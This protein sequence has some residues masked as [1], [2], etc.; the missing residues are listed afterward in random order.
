MLHCWASGSN[1]S[2]DRGA[3]TFRVKQ[4]KKKNLATF[5]GPFNPED[6]GTMI[7]GKQVN[8]Q[9][10]IISQNTQVINSTTVRTSDLPY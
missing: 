2:K 5:V 3:F 6:E 1:T 4:P 10:I 8:Q 9:H 7:L